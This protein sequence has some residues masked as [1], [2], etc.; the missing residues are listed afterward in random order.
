MLATEQRAA[1]VHVAAVLQPHEA[2]DHPFIA[3]LR[4]ADIP[5]TTI[6][7]GSKH[8]YKEYS[9]LRGVIS[10][11]SPSIVHTHGYRADIVGGIAARRCRVPVVSTVHGFTGGSWRNR[12]NEKLQLLALR[13]CSATIAVSRPLVERLTA[14]GVSP[15]RI[16][17]VPNAIATPTSLSRVEARRKLGLSETQPVAGWVGRL[18]HEKG[19]DVML[20]ALAL[21]DSDWQLSIIGDGPERSSL[22]RLADEEGIASRATFHGEVAN[23]ASF[24]NAFD[25]LVISSRTEGTPISLLEAMSLGVPIVATDVGGIPDVVSDSE[26]IIVRPEDPRAIAAALSEARSNV[27]ATRKRVEAARSRVRTNH[28]IQRWIDAIA[29]AYES[30]LSSRS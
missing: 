6:E 7:V 11:L 1:G 15:P 28:S 16:Y 19:P 25:A 29:A 14:A 13:R 21:S 18:S 8:Y 22:R 3:S 24:M 20:K 5:V 9:A 23:A 10:R 30:A 26:A 4:G 12:M 27:M 17:L 2:S